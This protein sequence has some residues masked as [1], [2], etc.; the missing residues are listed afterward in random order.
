MSE[1]EA[2]FPEGVTEPEYELYGRGE[3]AVDVD[4]ARVFADLDDED[5]A[6]RDRARAFALDEVAPVIDDYWDRAEYPVHLVRRLG[7]LDLLRD[8]VELE[9]APRQSRLAA[10][11]VNAELSRIDGSVGTILGVQGGLALRS[12]VDCGSPEQVQRWAARMAD[13]SL[14][15]AFALTEP[16]HGSDSVGLATSAVRVAGGWVLNGEKKWIGN[17]SLGPAL[18]ME[19][20]SVV[21]ARDEDGKVRGFAVP[22]DSEGYSAETI[23]GKLALRAIWQAHITLRN[24]FVP[25]ENLLPGANSFKDTSA[26]LFSTRLSVAW[27]AVGA[28][29]G[30]YETA[31]AYAR[32]REQFGRPLGASQIVNER[33]AR[34]Q[35]ELVQ[36]QL[37]AR[38]CVALE[39]RGE[40]TGAQASL[41][42]FTST[43]AA[44]SIAANARD[45]LGGNG[46]LVKN[47]A[48]RIFADVEALHTYEGTE[49]VQA[50]LI[51]RS[52]TG[53][54]TFS[55]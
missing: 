47:R 22:Q 21:W 25:D 42:K 43:R 24:V 55:G 48:A 30:A 45:L 5:A 26:V 54:S 51:G 41:A 8:G 9:G 23:K 33:L 44:R 27:G 10:G 14:P 19:A 34:M 52:V 3:H 29:M 20:L 11:L 32:Q 39:D 18:G 17:G 16:T 53:H 49:T 36:I 46:I 2:A 50:L 4:P 31:V 12:I 15:G 13:G 35:S 7:E 38:H 28:A 37:L 6:F 40:L 1:F